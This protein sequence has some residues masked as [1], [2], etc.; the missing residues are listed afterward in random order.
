MGGANRAKVAQ[1]R[2]GRQ[3][4]CGPHGLRQAEAMR[5][6]VLQKP[7]DAAVRTLGQVG[8][9]QGTL[10][11]EAGALARIGCSADFRGAVSECRQV[12]PVRL[13]HVRRQCVGDMASGV[14][15][16]GEAELVPAGAGVAL[17]ADLGRGPVWAGYGLDADA[18][19]EPVSAGAPPADTAHLI[20][21]TLAH[22][23]GV[24]ERSV[25][26]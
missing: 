21:E 19:G 1:L 9:D 16:M 6:G 23:P 17:A 11:V 5:E 25:G 4:G 26:Q 22:D 20:A 24:D 8:G 3:F 10:L 15:L 13:G 12:Q 2:Q 14:E 7:H 18:V